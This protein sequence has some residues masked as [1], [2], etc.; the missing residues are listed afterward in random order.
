MQNLDKGAIIS[1]PHV[2]VK[3]NFHLPL[4]IQKIINSSGKSI[5]FTRL[6]LKH[7]AEKG[8][9]GERML[10]LMGSILWSPEA[11][12]ASHM[13]SRFLIS[14]LYPATI[15]IKPHTVTIEVIEYGD[16]IVT[17]FTGK[18]KYFKNLK[19]LWGT[20]FPPSQ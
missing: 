6:S 7:L 8:G 1:D 17:G 16:I 10:N 15:G 9:D 11:V 20:A 5:S 19:L 2:L 14:K 12:H 13:P 3:T 18:N 4:E